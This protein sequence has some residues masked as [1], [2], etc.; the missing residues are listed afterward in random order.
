MMEAA[1]TPELL[2]QL[3]ALIGIKVPPEDIESL[4]GAL[5][6]QLRGVSLLQPLDLSTVEPLVTF[7]PRWS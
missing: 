1:L 6:N 5:A 7:D 3:A 2:E 4:L